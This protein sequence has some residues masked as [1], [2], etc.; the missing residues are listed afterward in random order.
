[1][2]APSRR[3]R[4]NRD[5]CLP[6]A[7]GGGQVPRYLAHRAKRA[8]RHRYR[9]TSAAAVET[10][11]YR[12]GTRSQYANNVLSLLAGLFLRWSIDID[13]ES[14]L[15]SA[16]TASPRCII[17]T[18]KALLIRLSS[19]LRHDLLPSRRIDSSLRHPSRNP[20]LRATQKFRRGSAAANCD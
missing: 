13:I 8:Q 1:M 6:Y 3:Y 2:P 12:T 20:S 4:N 9:V 11:C 10:P 15:N 17:T 14:S 18:S 7:V 5:S 16:A 19:S